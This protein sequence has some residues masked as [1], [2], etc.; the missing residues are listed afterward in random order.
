MPFSERSDPIAHPFDAICVAR[1]SRGGVRRRRGGR[2][3]GSGRLGLARVVGEGAAGRL[4]RNGTHVGVDELRCHRLDPWL[5]LAPAVD[6]IRSD[7]VERRVPSRREADDQVTRVGLLLRPI[8]R[9]T[10]NDVHRLPREVRRD[11]R[12]GVTGAEVLGPLRCD[13]EDL[14]GQ[15]ARSVLERGVAL[16]ERDRGGVVGGD[17]GHA[18]GGPGDGRPVRVGLDRAPPAVVARL[19]AVVVRRAGTGHQQ[20]R[21]DHPRRAPAHESAHAAQHRLPN[22]SGRNQGGIDVPLRS[23]PL[24][25]E[26]SMAHVGLIAAQFGGRSRL[27]TLDGTCRH[28]RDPVRDRSEFRTGSTVRRRRGALDDP[29]PEGCAIGRCGNLST[30]AVQ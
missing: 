20:H 30:A 2:R 16:S 23:G 15:V 9:R 28:N 8:L 3:R 13:A 5:A 1:S 25:S 4:H 21:C 11:V 24:F 10:T 7:L 19:V 14:V 29:G 18:I 12:V 6:P 17:V 26:R 27:G 22:R